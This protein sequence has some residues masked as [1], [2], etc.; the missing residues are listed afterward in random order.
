MAIKTITVTEDAYQAVK[1]LK[2]GE[3]SFSDLFLRLGGKS[4]TAKDI[5]GVLKHVPEE[6]AALKRSVRE[7]HEELSRG[8]EK[9]IED[10][11]SR[12]KRYH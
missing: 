3:E 10:V 2:K 4:I 11:R 6:T 5:L 7:I 1:R 8:M 9:R 12:L